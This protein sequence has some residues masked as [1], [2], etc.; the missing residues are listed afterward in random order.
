M[1]VTTGSTHRLD[2]WRDLIREHFVALD[3]DATDRDAPFAGSVRSAPVGHLSVATVATT[4]AEYRR[5]PG[6]A[7]ADGEAY[8]Q[9]GL[10]SR[11]AAVLRQDGREAVL[12]AGDYALYETERPFSWHMGGDVGL[13]VLT[14]PRST[15]AVDAAGSQRLTARAIDGGSGLGAIVGRV[16]RELVTGPPDLSPAGAVRLAGE[17]AELVTTVAA[18]QA[19]PE[20]AAGPAGELLCRIHGWVAEHL[21]DPGL[22]PAAVARAHY[23]STRHLHRLFAGAGTTVARHI[24]AER[25]D[26]CRRELAD[27]R[28]TAP[29][30]DI[31]RRW[32]FPDAASLSRAFRQAYGTSPSDYRR[33]HRPG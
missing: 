33:Q 3:I 31:A 17:V 15:V 9:V 19:A 20:P 6:L 14:W 24:R 27:P 10:V 12:R 26:R 23:L 4:G 22:D 1:V 30:F 18:E 8:L 28:G 7:R 13:L 2:R 25:L 16:L 29:V 21:A 5:T 11:G 32:G